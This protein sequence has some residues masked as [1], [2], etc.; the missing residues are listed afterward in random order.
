MKTTYKQCSTSFFFRVFTHV[1]LPPKS[2]I[3]NIDF[4][5]I[6]NPLMSYFKATVPLRS[7]SSPTYRPCHCCH[8]VTKLY[9]TFCDPVDYSPTGSSLHGILQAR[10]LEWVAMSFSRGSSRPADRTHISCIGSRILH[11]WATWEA[12]MGVSSEETLFSSSR[13]PSLIRSGRD[14]LSLSAPALVLFRVLAWV[15]IF[16][17]EV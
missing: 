11:C 6:L 7:M 8:S 17:S 9:L 1:R 4:C 12:L 14:H 13:K 3:Y 5:H 15:G 16:T 2:H 10:I